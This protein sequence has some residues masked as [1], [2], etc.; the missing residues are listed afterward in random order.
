VFAKQ[1]AIDQRRQILATRV[2]Q[3]KTVLDQIGR[4]SHLRCGVNW[5]DSDFP[6]NHLEKKR[7]TRKPCKRNQPAAKETSL[8][9]KKKSGASSP[10]LKIVSTLFPRKFGFDLD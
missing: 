10:A 3:F 6:K 8:P 4:C 1:A 9:Q 7:A 5:M 2:G